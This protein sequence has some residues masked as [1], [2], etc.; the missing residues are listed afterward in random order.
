MVGLNKP[1]RW[2]KSFELFALTDSGDTKTLLWQPSRNSH[3]LKLSRLIFQFVLTAV[4]GA[5]QTERGVGPCAGEETRTAGTR[6]QT[7][8]A[9]RPRDDGHEQ[10]PDINNPY[11]FQFSFLQWRIQDSRR[12]RQPQPIIWQDFPESCIKTKRIWAEAGVPKI[13]RC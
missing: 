5:E 11:F 13:C 7:T 3:L 2:L 6:P 8:A 12:R 4:E 9:H 10:P 1:Y